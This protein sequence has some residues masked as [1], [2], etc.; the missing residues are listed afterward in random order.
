MKYLKNRHN[1]EIKI[2]NLGGGFGVPEITAYKIADLATL[3]IRRLLRKPTDFSHRPF[4]FRKMASD[5]VF[6][7]ERKLD[8]YRLPYPRLMLEPG[9]SL[10]GNTTHLLT[11]ILEVKQ[12]PKNN[13]LII[14]AGTNLMPVLTFYSEHH[15]I[16]VETRSKIKQ[17]TSI[18]GPLLYSSDSLV[19]GRVLPEGKTSDAVIICDTGAYFACQANQFLYPR[20]AS[21]LIDGKNSRVIERRETTSDLFARIV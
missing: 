9:R 12:T 21:V 11:T 19:S 6:H 18:A 5:I 14:D 2:L 10:V 20:A 4:N 17:I 8:E 13:W 7:L 15:D 1:C 3:A 16:L